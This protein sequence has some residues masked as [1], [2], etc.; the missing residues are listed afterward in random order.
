MSGSRNLKMAKLEDARNVG[1]S[2]GHTGIFKKR[3]YFLNYYTTT[4][5]SN[6]SIHNTLSDE[7]DIQSLNFHHNSVLPEFQN[8]W[9][10]FTNTWIITLQMIQLYCIKDTSLHST[11]SFSHL[12]PQGHDLF[13]WLMI[14]FISIS[15]HVHFHVCAFFCVSYTHVK[16]SFTFEILTACFVKPI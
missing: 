13:L 7:K 14:T 9:K 6:W 3:E 2:V 4:C 11:I 5:I 1:I 12:S 15:Q 8:K 10:K 16:H